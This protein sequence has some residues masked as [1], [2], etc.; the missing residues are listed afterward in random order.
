[1]T[2]QFSS[3][4]IAVITRKRSVATSEGVIYLRSIF[5]AIM[6]Q[7]L[8]WGLL[9]HCISPGL[10]LY[11]PSRGSARSQLLL[12][13]LEFRDYI[14]ILI[15]LKIYCIG[16]FWGK[17]AQT[18]GGRR[19]KKRRGKNEAINSRSKICV[20]ESK[21]SGKDLKQQRERDTKDKTQNSRKE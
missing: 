6:F 20:P 2:T 21:N 17:N 4:P 19:G 8:H 15:L 13:I 3:V 7:D 1:M 12:P 16:F 14:W 9:D 11:L 5:L 18:D 10:L